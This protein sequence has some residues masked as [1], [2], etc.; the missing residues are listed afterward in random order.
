MDEKRR[1]AIW[2]G[3]QAMDEPCGKPEHF[4]QA[5]RDA[6]YVICPVE[7]TEEMIAVA[8]YAN[9]TEEGKDYVRFRYRAMIQK[10][11]G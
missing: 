5:L 11:G 1:E 3:Y 8:G 4:E 9:A 6:G 10:A 7:P 2:A